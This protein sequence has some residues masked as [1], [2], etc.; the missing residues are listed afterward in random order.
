M[1]VDKKRKFFHQEVTIKDSSSLNSYDSAS[2]PFTN[3]QF[4][5]DFPHTTTSSQAL[6]HL[7]EAGLSLR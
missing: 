5:L 4:W 3:L 2:A 6:R 1:R 7:L